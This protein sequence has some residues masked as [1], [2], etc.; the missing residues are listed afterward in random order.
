Q[1]DFR[2][3][4][5]GSTPIPILIG[6]D[7]HETL[8]ADIL[9]GGDPIHR[10]TAS[11]VDIFLGAVSGDYPSLQAATAWLAGVVGTK[12]VNMSAGWGNNGGGDSIRERY[13]DW[14]ATSTNTLFVKSA[15]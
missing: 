2:N 11:G 1:F 8:V 14:L 4:V 6:E 12:V 5:I 15:G 9:G 10:G 3:L 7:G 13:L